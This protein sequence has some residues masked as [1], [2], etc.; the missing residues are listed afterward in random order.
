MESG[1]LR[2]HNAGEHGAIVLIAR[3][4]LDDLH[5]YFL[6]RDGRSE[7]R[8]VG[9]GHTEFARGVNRGSLEP[10]ELGIIAH[11]SGKLRGGVNH[12]FYRT[13]GS[14]AGNFNEGRACGRINTGCATRGERRQSGR[15]QSNCVAVEQVHTIDFAERLGPGEI[16][17][18]TERVDDGER[19]GEG[20]PRG[21]LGVGQTSPRG[22]L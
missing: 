11:A 2:A 7:L 10:P 22:G 16:D 18:R 3:E 15:N 9:S 4:T 13:G 1:K 12:V 19:L 17:G 21:S 6:T 8:G 14:H 20:V 5:K